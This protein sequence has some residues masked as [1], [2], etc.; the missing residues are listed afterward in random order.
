MSPQEEHPLL[1]AIQL[2]NL[3]VLEVT[4]AHRNLQGGGAALISAQTSNGGCR[5]TWVGNTR[6]Y[7]WRQQ[8]LRL[9]TPEI[10]AHSEWALT[11]ENQK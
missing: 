11:E 8:H 2:A 10:W 1:L 9:L 6:G 7:L 5:L 3:R 4:S